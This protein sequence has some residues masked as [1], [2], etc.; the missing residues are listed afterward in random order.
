MTDFHINNLGLENKHKMSPV[1][2][3]QR[4]RAS[5][6]EDKE[7]PQLKMLR[8]EDKSQSLDENIEREEGWENTTILN[9][10][11]LF[12]ARYMFGLFWKIEFYLFIKQI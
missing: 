1:E 9:D 2:P 4:D 11:V 8:M 6:L 10:R 5:S 3:M 7:V 12:R